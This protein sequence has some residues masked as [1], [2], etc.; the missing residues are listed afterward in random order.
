MAAV[1]WF[2]IRAVADQIYAIEE[3]G[4]VQCYLVNGRKRSALIDTGLGL[5]PLRP[6]LRDLA[7]TEIVVLNTHWHFDHV[8]GN[9]EFETIAIAAEEHRLIQR[10]IAN[11]TLRQLYID[12][13]RAGGPELPPGFNPAGYRYPGSIPTRHLADGDTIDLGGRRLLARATPGHTRGSLSFQDT[14][15]GALLCGDL[16]YAGT[17]YA[18]FEDSD[19][20]A[21][22]RSLARLGAEPEIRMLL[23]G[24]N[25]YPLD[26]AWLAKAQRLL[27]AALVPGAPFGLDTEWGPPVRRYA[28]DG[29]DLL[30]PVPG[31]PGVDLRARLWPASD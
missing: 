19:V 14:R 10:A 20:A 23:P 22:R 4:H 25:G 31:R 6:V 29:L 2:R 5:V 1:A 24:H 28:G 8:M 3:P 17:L 18:H 30:A 26:A 9:P 11:A 27:E 12:P 16:V 13:C 7:L 15:T 21:Y